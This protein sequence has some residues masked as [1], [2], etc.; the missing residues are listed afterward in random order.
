MLNQVAASDTFLSSSR[1]GGPSSSPRLC[2]R[3]QGGFTLVEL[4]VVIAIIGVL[5][6][7]LLPAVQA[8]REAARRSTCQARMKQVA[9]AMLNFESAKK[10]LP[11]GTVSPI[12]IS[13]RSC[14]PYGAWPASAPGGGEVYASATFF[15]EI[16]PYVEQQALFDR[17][18][19]WA[20]TTKQRAI[21][22]PEC[23]TPVDTFLCP[24][25]RIAP[26]LTTGNMG[27][28]E[29]N[30]QGFSGNIVGCASNGYMDRLDTSD[31]KFVRFRAPSPHTSLEVNGL[32]YAG[33]QVRLSKITDGLSNTAL[34]SELVLVEDVGLSDIKGR[35]YNGSHGSVLFTTHKTPNSFDPNDLDAHPWCQSEVPLD[36]KKCRDTS[37]SVFITARSHHP[38]IVNFGY[39]DGSVTTMSDGVD[40]VVYRAAGSRNGGEVV[41]AER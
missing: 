28:S 1:R 26:K 13:N 8:A 31:P 37:S 29:Y 10:R 11:M 6:A 24:S 7:L 5:V 16:L 20:R 32:I 21:Y 41:S 33:S 12:D 35:Y 9:L 18:D 2:S 22:F 3:P 14:P 36:V 34:V 30:S 39:A 19:E 4:L 40:A 38:G 23:L 25:D 17:F 15:H 27:G